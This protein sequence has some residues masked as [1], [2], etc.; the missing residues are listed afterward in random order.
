MIWF[1]WLNL[2][3][4]LNNLN[5]SYIWLSHDR[6]TLRRNY[7]ILLFCLLLVVITK[8]WQLA[9]RSCFHQ[10]LEIL[11][12]LLLL[13]ASFTMLEHQCFFDLFLNDFFNAICVELCFVISTLGDDWEFAKVNIFNLNAI[14]LLTNWWHIY[15]IELNGIH[16]FIIVCFNNDDAFWLLFLVLIDVIYHVF[17]Q[18]SWNVTLHSLLI[19]NDRA[20]LFT[21]LNA[22][23]KISKFVLHLLFNWQICLRTLI[24]SIACFLF[25]YER[26]F[27]LKWVFS[28]NNLCY[29]LD[30]LFVV[31]IEP[32]IDLVVFLFKWL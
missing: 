19:L 27:D 5:S 20:L 31:F 26:L 28:I 13:D 32:N 6:R 22:L 10:H 3:N 16:I 1:S 23:F 30:S 9:C 15:F 29:I 14:A 11:K 25:V 4:F 21:I 24:D 2:F 18:G 7:V 12:N 8:C 17:Y